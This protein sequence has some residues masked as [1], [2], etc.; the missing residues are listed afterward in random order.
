MISEW[1]RGYVAAIQDLH[2]L[3]VS[4]GLMTEGWHQLFEDVRQDAQMIDHE[5]QNREQ[6]A[7][8]RAKREVQLELLP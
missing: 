3:G 1:A 6:R 4:R 7:G 8:L 2:K 5:I